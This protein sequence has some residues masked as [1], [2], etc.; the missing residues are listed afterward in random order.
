MRLKSPALSFRIFLAIFVQ[1]IIFN[2]KGLLFSVFWT[3]LSY[4]I[5]GAENE[6]FQPC[7]NTYLAPEFRPNVHYLPTLPIISV[8]VPSLRPFVI[9]TGVYA[10]N[11]LNLVPMLPMSLFQKSEVDFGVTITRHALWVTHISNHSFINRCAVFISVDCLFEGNNLLL[12]E[13]LFNI[14]QT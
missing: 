3:I 7:A 6:L 9:G 4:A 13:N 11:I 14:T 12:L 1:Y 2:S 5:S 8:V 10:G